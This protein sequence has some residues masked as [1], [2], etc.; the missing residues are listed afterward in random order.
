MFDDTCATAAIA[1]EVDARIQAEATHSI[2]PDRDTAAALTHEYVMSCLAC[3]E[4]GDGTLFMNLHQGRFLY[5]AAAGQWYVWSGHFWTMDIEGRALAAVE[6]VSLAYVNALTCISKKLS[7]TEDEAAAEALKA[8][9]KLLIRRIDWLR[10]V[11]GRINCLIF[12]TTLPT[13]A[14]PDGKNPLVITGEKLDQNPWLLACQNGVIH[15]ETGSFRPGRPADLLTKPAPHPFPENIG[16]YLATGENTPA[17]TWERF[18]WEVMDGDQEMVDYL[19]RLLGYCVTGSTRDHIFIVFTG[20]GRNG[21]STLLEILSKVVGEIAVAIKPEMLLD[22]RRV[23]SSAGADADVM[24]LKGRRVAIASEADDNQGFSRATVKR[25]TGGDSISAR[26]PHEKFQVTF[27]PTHKLIF[28]TNDIP[29][30]NPNDRAFWLR[31]HL[32][33]FPLSFVDNPAAPNERQVD[34]GL[35]ARLEAEAGGILAWLV[36]GALLYKQRGLDPP[37]KVTEATA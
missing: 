24:A 8:Q 15:L 16:P 28:S 21:K 31:M 11:K 26:S 4:L 20:T 18:L 17:P 2:P 37:K 19:Q 14:L 6:K 33:N 23:R 29:R 34:K 25:L 32:V 10:K 22:Q 7:T 13:E 3:N 12:A 35:P 9:R 30:A 5:D 27:R 36:R 1:A